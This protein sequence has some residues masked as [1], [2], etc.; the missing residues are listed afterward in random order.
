[1]GAPA[2]SPVDRVPSQTKPTPSGQP[3]FDHTHRT[4]GY[5]SITGHRAGEAAVAFEHGADIEALMPKLRSNDY[6][7]EPRVQELAAKERAEPGYC[8]KVK[9]FT[10]GRKG[11]G[12]VK[13]LDEIDVRRL[14]LE[15][16]VQ[17]NK[18]EVLVYMD[19]SKKPP[20][21]QGLNK[22]AEVTLLGV[23]GYDKRTG[24]T[25]T[26][27]PDLER[28]EKRLRK[29]TEEQGAE[30]ISFDAG[31]GEWKFR[32]THFSRY[33]LHKSEKPCL[34]QAAS[35]FVSCRDGVVVD[36]AAQFGSV[37]ASNF[38]AKRMG[39]ATLDPISFGT[40]I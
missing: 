5:A 37:F 35:P 28:F 15:G 12:S 14:D 32:V 9:D 24:Q 22:P 16:I 31:K 3:N 13:W 38:V 20:V 25:V 27:G 39:E 34:L 6:Y 17:F 36:W 30:F 1:M 40:A 8:R 19:E 7:T 18:C 33:G 21:G 23:K 29:K 2:P 4:N 26:E 10:V 11:Y